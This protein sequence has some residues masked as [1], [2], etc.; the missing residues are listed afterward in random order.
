MQR[1]Q[2]S[3]AWRSTP[4]RTLSKHFRH[5]FR[6]EIIDV[7]GDGH[8][9]EYPLVFEKK[10]EISVLVTFNTNASKLFVGASVIFKK[11]FGK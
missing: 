9:Q 3:P 10:L 11:N 8:E 2:L 5:S 6:S 7:L 4:T 1:P